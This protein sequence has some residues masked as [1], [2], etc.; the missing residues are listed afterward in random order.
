MAEVE[1]AVE[2]AAEMT[3]EK[4]HEVADH[5]PEVVESLLK[6]KLGFTALGV[7][8]GAAAGGI[9]AFRLAHRR[10]RVEYAKLAEEEI[11]QMREHFRAR[12]VAK[13]S[14]PNLAAAPAEEIV[15]TQRYAPDDPHVTSIDRLKPPV[16]VPPGEPVTSSGVEKQNV[17]EQHGQG[18]DSWDMQAEVASREAGGTYVIHTDEREEI[19]GYSQ[20]T[21]TF[22][23]KDGVLCDEDDKVI[24]E[25]DGL[26]GPPENL[27]FGHGSGD[28][29]VVYIRN[30]HLEVELEIVKSPNSYAEEVHGFSHAEEPRRRR[31]SS[32]KWDD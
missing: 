4:V 18:P 22:Y 7:A 27:R 3:A 30:E 17:F 12:L 31:P 10:L 21:L 29:N 19:E 25:E 1:Q 23:A 13:E 5:I 2:H 20:A 26:V 28:P 8:V 16:P 14:K 11:D 24:N 15:R 9:I 32:P 6:M